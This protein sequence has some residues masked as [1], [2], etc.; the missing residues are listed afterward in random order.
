MNSDLFNGEVLI[1]HLLDPL[2]CP[3]KRIKRGVQDTTLLTLPQGCVLFAF[4]YI[5][6]TNDC[7]SRYADRYI[8]KYTDDLCNRQPSRRR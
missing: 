2:Q 6:Y 3:Y 1:E 7:C 4:L 8:L 5:L